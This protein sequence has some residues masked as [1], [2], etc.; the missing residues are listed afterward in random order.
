MGAV[1]ILVICG[2]LFG[3]LIIPKQRQLKR[4]TAL[5]DSLAVGDEVMTGTGIYGTITRLEPDFAYVEIAP[6]VVVKL[7][8]RAVASK[9]TAAA[10][11][12]SP[13]VNPADDDR[14]SVDHDA[15]GPEG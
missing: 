4:H 9:V 2:L 1:F 15:D 14:Q 12:P 5:V 11:G 13:M 8:R 6:T 10:P 7:A 3:V